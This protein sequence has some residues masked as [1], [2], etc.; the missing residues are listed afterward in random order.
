MV[1]LS[2]KASSDTKMLATVMVVAGIPELA[3]V[4]AVARLWLSWQQIPL[5]IVPY[6]LIGLGLIYYFGVI[7]PGTSH[8]IDSKELV[9]RHGP[10]FRLQIARD[11]IASLQEFKVKSHSSFGV[12]QD[13]TSGLF[14]VLSGNRNTLCLRLREPVL[15]KGWCKN[16]GYIQQVVFNVDH[17]GFLREELHGP[18]PEP[19]PALFI[20]PVP[21]Q[22]ES[23]AF[24]PAPAAATGPSL[25]L[26]GVGKQYQEVAAV[27]SLSLHLYPGEVF[28]L[29]GSNGAGKTTTLKMMSGLLQPTKGHIDRYGNT[30]AY[31]PEST[32]P[33]ERM[34]GREFLRF[35]GVLYDGDAHSSRL[36]I[37]EYLHRFDL[38]PV[39]DRVI[40][41]YSQGMKR[42][43][44]LIATLLKNSSLIL[45]DE[46]TNGMDPAGIIKVKN[47]MRQLAASGKT[48]VFSTH[49]LEM[50]ERLCDRVGIMAG[51]H[52]V[53]N[54]SLD[55]LRLQTAKP[56]AS[57]EEIFLSLV[58]GGT[59]NAASL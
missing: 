2:R 53:F 9:I 21:I 29:L 45:L 37:E 12:F 57:L 34:S 11:N 32:V 5:V 41:S 6:A 28:G 47:T 54:G 15:V 7:I 18:A 50:A 52:L 36:H 1:D 43:I 59:R 39:A 13:K 4:V 23:S 27:E 20:Q 30:I 58:Y 10:W 46:P 56:D 3:I 14:H 33:Y 24:T 22:A 42:K 35:L 8:Q 44:C 51:G 25:S 19:E 38:L 49:I 26:H 40:A 16:Y 48:V 17:P 55:E 31:M